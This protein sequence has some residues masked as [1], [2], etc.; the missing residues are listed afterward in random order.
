MHGAYHF[1]Q[2]T[3]ASGSMHG[4][5]IIA[6][7]AGMQ[8]DKSSRYSEVKVVTRGGCSP[9]APPRLPAAAP[10]QSCI[11]GGSLHACMDDGHE[12][13]VQSGVTRDRA[14]RALPLYNDLRYYL[15]VQQP[16]SSSQARCSSCPQCGPDYFR[17][18]DTSNCQP[19]SI[20]NDG[21][22]L[23][24]SPMPPASCTAGQ[25]L[26]STPWFPSLPAQSDFVK[27][28]RDFLCT[29]G[30]NNILYWFDT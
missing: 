4:G 29:A 2:W 21:G 28:A 20:F 24:C 6:C 11:V 8:W 5:S 25:G 15:L 12:E 10:S 17:E 14:A 9:P 19:G 22:W 7:H 27:V 18:F 26:Q 23:K 13:E 30:L 1:G 16:L 3:P